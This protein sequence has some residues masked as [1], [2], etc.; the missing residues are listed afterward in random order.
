M[1]WRGCGGRSPRP[2]HLLWY[3]RR[4][5]SVSVKATMPTI[6]VV[7][8]T[9]R[10][11]RPEDGQAIADRLLEQAEA[12]QPSIERAR[13]DTAAQEEVRRAEEGDRCP[14]GG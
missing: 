3:Y 12:S 13:V 10:A 5:W 11:F 1:R 7:I 2:E 14:P 4:R 6:G 8:L 9:V